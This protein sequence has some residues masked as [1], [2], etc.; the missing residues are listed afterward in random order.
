MLNVNVWRRLGHGSFSKAE[1]RIDYTTSAGRPV[2]ASLTVPRSP[3][4]STG[5][6]LSQ[7]TFI[8]LNQA[9]RDSLSGASITHMIL[10][11]ARL[12]KLRY[13]LMTGSFL[14]ASAS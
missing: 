5:V 8:F 14:A 10:P 4:S 9:A 11:S 3:S 2:Q 13:G 12:Q 1:D 6:M 7:G